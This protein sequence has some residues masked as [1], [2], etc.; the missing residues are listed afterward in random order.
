MDKPL[1][2]VV[3][4]LVDSN[5]IQEEPNDSLKKARS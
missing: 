1:K 5:E 2:G 3:K 4:P